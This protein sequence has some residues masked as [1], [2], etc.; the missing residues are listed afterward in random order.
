[1]L[2]DGLKRLWKCIIILRGARSHV[3]VCHQPVAVNGV[4]TKL[5]SVGLHL[6]RRLSR[7][8]TD[9]GKQRINSECRTNGGVFVLFN[10]GKPRVAGFITVLRTFRGLRFMSHHQQ[11]R[12]IETTTCSVSFHAI[13]TVC[14]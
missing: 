6:A 5:F 9:A 11:Q 7:A 3:A 10:G 12:C 13:V 2:A 1:M 14:V 4:T 8:T